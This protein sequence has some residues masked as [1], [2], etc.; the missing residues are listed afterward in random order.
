MTGKMDSHAALAL[1]GDF[2]RHYYASEPHDH[3]A[4]TNALTSL[5]HAGDER[6]RLKIAF[7]HVLAVDYPAQALR[8]LVRDQANR[9]VE[10]D[11]EARGFLWKVYNLNVLD[12]AVPPSDEPKHD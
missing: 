4:T 11:R 7:E 10:N 1:V 5:L 2:L 8:D 12:C 3:V 9:P 6:W